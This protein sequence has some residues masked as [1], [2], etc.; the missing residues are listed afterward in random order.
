MVK[1]SPAPNS[2]ARDKV[3]PT[4][5]VFALFHPLHL[6][7][8]P[9]KHISTYDLM[10]VYNH[11]I[12]IYIYIHVYNIYI[13]IQYVYVSVQNIDAYWN[14]SSSGRDPMLHGIIRLGSSHLPSQIDQPTCQDICM[15]DLCGIMFTEGQHAEIGFVLHLTSAHGLRKIIL[16]AR[17]IS[18][19]PTAANCNTHRLPVL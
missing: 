1:T 14:C 3:T 13:Y 7:Y 4:E 9:F 18:L 15:W 11:I 5:H 16:P 6:L 17:N 10:Y 2:L 19:K 12:Y 8:M